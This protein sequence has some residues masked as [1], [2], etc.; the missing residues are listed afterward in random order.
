MKEP[1]KSKMLTLDEM[2]KLANKIAIRDWN[3]DFFTGTPIVHLDQARSSHFMR[4]EIGRKG[5]REDPGKQTYSLRMSSNTN[6][7]QSTNDYSIRIPYDVDL[8][9]Y[10]GADKRVARL[11]C[12]ASSSCA[13]RQKKRTDAYI[14]S[15]KRMSKQ[16]DTNTSFALQE[17]LALAKLGSWDKS[18]SD[19]RHYLLRPSFK[20]NEFEEYCLE[21]S[22]NSPDPPE[23]RADAFLLCHLKQSDQLAG[24]YRIWLVVHQGHAAKVEQ[25]VG[26]H[27]GTDPS[28][29]QLYQKIDRSYHA[30]HS[31]LMKEELD[32]ARGLLRNRKREDKRGGE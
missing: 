14:R 22:E 23:G 15:V 1:M 25:I 24:T 27:E 2:V 32:T 26:D 13:K 16:D 10:S 19:E 6:R 30:M 28:L 17:M 8:G 29:A 21:L 5:A 31:K 7:A 9:S 3:D 18:D 20:G 11:Y 12:A 4:I